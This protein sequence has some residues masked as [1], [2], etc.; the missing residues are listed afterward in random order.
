MW[1]V[2]IVA[3]PSR[4][5]PR[6]APSSF[7]CAWI[8]STWAAPAPRVLERRMRRALELD[9]DRRL[10]PRLPS[11]AHVERRVG[12]PPVVDIASPRRRPRRSAPRDS[13][14]PPRPRRNP[15]AAPADHVWLRARRVQRLQHL[16][17][18]VAH[19]VRRELNRRLHRRDRERRRSRW[20]LEMSADRAA[21][22]RSTRRAPRCRSSRSCIEARAG[23]YEV[24]R[25]DPRHFPRTI[26]CSSSRSRRCSSP[27]D[28]T[29][30][31]CERE[32]EGAEG[33]AHAG[34]EARRP[35][36]YGP[37]FVE[38]RRC[39]A[40]ARSRALRRDTITTRSSR[41][42]CTSTTGAGPRPR[43]T[44]ATGAA[45]R[46]EMM[47]AIEFRRRLHPPFEGGAG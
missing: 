39:P 17:L 16:H 27:I 21:T 23:Y 18:L 28:F 4:I 25:R 5:A 36:Q 42:S 24:G 30:T 19:R 2:R 7:G 3:L 45:R 38:A 6:G 20:F 14:A 10:A 29:A 9:R 13:F 32:G 34:P 8:S 35:G 11:Q 44:C 47:I 31:R 40:T 46:R 43:S 1:T 33:D 41:R 12:P 26:C 15:R 22:D 37:G